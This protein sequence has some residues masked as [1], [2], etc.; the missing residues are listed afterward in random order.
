[1]RKLLQKHARVDMFDE[2]GMA[3]LHLA[4]ENGHCLVADVLLEHK[5]FVNAKSKSG[6][7]PLHLAAQNGVNSLVKLLLEKHNAAIDAVTLVSF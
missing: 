6:L 7:T 4:A 5:A 3:A 2:H 1:M